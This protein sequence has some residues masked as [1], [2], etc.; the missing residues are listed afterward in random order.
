MAQ[1]WKALAS[2]INNQ[3][4]LGPRESNQLLTALTSSFRKHLNEVHPSQ[5]HDEARRPSAKYGS[6]GSNRQ[7]FH[8][9]IALADQHMA[10]VLTNSL[11]VKSAKAETVPKP[12][13]DANTAATELK[14]GAN[15]FDLLELYHAKGYATVDVALI[16]MK[17]FRRSIKELTYGEQVAK[18]QGEHGGRRVLSWLWASDVLHS[19]AYVDN[20]QI[21]D[22]LVWLVIM[23]GQEDFLWQWLESDLELPQSSLAKGHQKN[24]TGHFWKSRIVYAMVM[25]K[26]GAPHRQ[27]RSAD[28]A[29]EVYFRAVQL[30]QHQKIAGVRD[31]SFLT[32]R[33]R[34]ALEKALMH[35]SEYHYSNTSPSLYDKFVNVYKN[36][37]LNYAYNAQKYALDNF[38]RAQLDIWH[39]SQPS[40]DIWNK[41]L[42]RDVLP[43]DSTTVVRELLQNPKTSG[44]TANYI[45]TFARAIAL[46]KNAGKH[47][48]S[49][50]LAT[51]AQSYYPNNIS[52]LTQAL[53]D[54]SPRE[55]GIEGRGK[56]SE[57][58]Q[59]EHQHQHNWLSSYFPAPT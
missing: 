53:Q 40:A 42:T 24:Q 52:Q 30:L 11:L 1:S 49:E 34:Q 6:E 14:N 44:D 9:S 19:Q 5:T 41:I 37:E 16:C 47:T 12:E 8:S 28:A 48:E 58:E 4:P 2:K 56:K 13:L 51:I 57:K 22:G 26:L 31:K 17:H 21:Q 45:K 29:L 18:V 54:L 50:Q 59:H 15:P 55:H 23:E 38:S 43:G 33:A 20:L 46:M 25:T 35:G 3:A 27:A 10:S 32:S 7:A 36:H 39:P